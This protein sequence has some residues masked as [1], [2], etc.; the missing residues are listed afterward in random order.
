MFSNHWRFGLHTY[1]TTLL[2]FCTPGN[3]ALQ[4]LFRSM[5]LSCLGTRE[6]YGIPMLRFWPV[7]MTGVIVGPI[8]ATVFEGSLLP[9]MV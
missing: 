1:L 2:M 9:F 6:L 7:C 3:N 8:Y 4:D 5:E